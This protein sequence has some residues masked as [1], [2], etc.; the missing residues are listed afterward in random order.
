M[1]RIKFFRPLYSIFVLFLL[2]CSNSTSVD[3]DEKQDD[4]GNTLDTATEIEAYYPNSRNDGIETWKSDKYS[5][6]YQDIDMFILKIEKDVEFA[7]ST[8]EGPWLKGRLLDEQGN[9]L[10]TDES[11]VDKVDLLLQAEAKAGTIYFV[12]IKPYNASGS[13]CLFVSTWIN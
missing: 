8:Y 10:S 5:I 11:N 1:I 7:V 13:Y 2:S 12:E 6:E 4:V 9:T 3:G